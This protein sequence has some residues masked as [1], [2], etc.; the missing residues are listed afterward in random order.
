MKEL[1]NQ[2]FEIP[3]PGG[4]RSTK[5]KLDRILN[6]F[7]IRT[8]KGEWKLNNHERNRI[9]RH[10]GYMENEGNRFEKL[11][12]NEQ[13]K[14]EK[15]RENEQKKFVKLMEKKQKELSELYAKMFQNSGR[16]IR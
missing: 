10:L 1:L 12:E 8:S 5:M 2:E 3:C 14:F 7:T 11:I 13:K 16:I 15:L 9:R 6:S 4:G